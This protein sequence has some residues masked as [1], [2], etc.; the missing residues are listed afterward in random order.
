MALEWLAGSI[1]WWPALSVHHLCLLPSRSPEGWP[2]CNTA[3]LPTARVLLMQAQPSAIPVLN[4]SRYSLKTLHS[5]AAIQIFMLLSISVAL[6][7]CIYSQDLY[8]Y[9]NPKFTKLLQTVWTFFLFFGGWKIPRT[10][11][12]MPLIKMTHTNKHP[13]YVAVLTVPLSKSAKQ[14]LACK[15]DGW[16]QN[17]HFQRPQPNYSF[18]AHFQG[19]QNG[20]SFPQ[21]F[22]ISKD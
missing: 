3:A 12:K 13:K 20:R 4:I 19:P 5:K 1:P 10:N 9:F 2:T 21:T 16:S 8:K 22:K 6:S 11:L 17:S 14:S 18:L 7:L 15:V